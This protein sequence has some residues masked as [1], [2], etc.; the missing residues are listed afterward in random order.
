MTVFRETRSYTGNRR[1]PFL[2]HIIASEQ[3]SQ[4]PLLTP[5]EAMRLTEDGALVFIAG[6]PPIFGRKLRYYEDPVFRARA[7]ISPP[8]KPDKIGHDWSR[9]MDREI[10]KA[11]LEGTKHPRRSGRRASDS[12]IAGDDLL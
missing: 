11:S 2:F 5:D 9:W 10:P 6:S 4:R 3:E 8:T 12:K 7:S 1:A